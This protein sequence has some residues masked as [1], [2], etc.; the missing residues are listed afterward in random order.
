ML[1]TSNSDVEVVEETLKRILADIELFF[2]TVVGEETDEMRKS[3]LLE[4]E[5]RVSFL[6]LF[7]S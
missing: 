2:A 4:L 3:N 6:L 5:F 1:A 7:D